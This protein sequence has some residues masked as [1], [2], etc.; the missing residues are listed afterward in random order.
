ML[1]Y[2]FYF[3]L[4]N[5]VTI[6]QIA[7]K[8]KRKLFVSHIYILAYQVKLCSRESM[9]FVFIGPPFQFGPQ[10]LIVCTHLIASTHHHPNVG[11]LSSS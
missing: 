2:Y 8:L 3:L 9:L 5:L 4:I 6:D 7:N 11:R 1:Y 10:S